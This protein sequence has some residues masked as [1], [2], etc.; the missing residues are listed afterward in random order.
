MGYARRTR[1]IL[2]LKEPFSFIILS[3]LV[4]ITMP[5][6]NEWLLEKAHEHVNSYIKVA[7]RKASILLTG[8]L[9]FSG[10]VGNIIRRNWNSMGDWLRFSISISGIIMFLAITFALLVVFPRSQNNDEKG[11]LFWE[12]VRNHNGRAG[13]ERA[14][15]N[16]DGDDMIRI[17]SNEVHDVSSIATKKYDW[18][19]R[20]LKA[21]YLVLLIVLGSV[22]IKLSGS[23][24][25]SFLL[26]S[27]F[28]IPFAYYWT[29]IEWAT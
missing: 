28:L 21:T 1:I 6:D 3:P 8:Q 16:L 20:S 14:I 18:L 2:L 9:T 4:N 27:L 11:I 23:V 19:N 7:D 10:L 24:A 17:L 25:Y 29:K 26:F 15:K 12:K 13:Y 5:R 22:I